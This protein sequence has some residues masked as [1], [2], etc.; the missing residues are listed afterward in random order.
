MGEPFGLAAEAPAAL[1]KMK[2]IAMGGIVIGPKNR[3]EPFACATM[4][5][6]QEL[7]FPGTS[8]R[9]VAVNADA[10]AIFEHER[11]HIYCRCARMCRTPA[12]P[13]NVSTGIA[14]HRF[15]P[16]KWTAQNLASCPINSITRPSAECLCGIAGHRP[17][18]ADGKKASV[19]AD[20]R[21]LD[22]I[23]RIASPAEI[24]IG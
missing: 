14:A 24:A 11:S 8:A 7:A 3:A 5:Y 9:P 16:G 12:G 4:H 22:S 6:S 13:G 21:K 17:D 18:I 15:D 19:S 23:D 1:L 10:A 2:M 20:C